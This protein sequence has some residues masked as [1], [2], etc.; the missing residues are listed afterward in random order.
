MNKTKKS[1][2][3]SKNKNKQSRIKKN[4][5][6]RFSRIKGG[7]A[8]EEAAEKRFKRIN[9]NALLS[10]AFEGVIRLLPPT[11]LSSTKALNKEFRGKVSGMVRKIEPKPKFKQQINHSNAVQLRN[12][13]ELRII[14]L[15]NTNID[16]EIL[17]AIVDSV[18]SLNAP[19]KNGGENQEVIAEIINI[20]LD[21]THVTDEGIIAMVKKF[22]KLEHITLNNIKGVTDASII[23]IAE[24]CPDL[25]KIEIEIVAVTENGLCALADSCDKLEKI[26]LWGNEGEGDIDKGII[27]IAKNCLKLREISLD[28]TGVT[29]ESIIAIAENCP[30]L[31][32]LEIENIEQEDLA[33]IAGEVGEG[34]TDKGIIAIA[35]NCPKLEHL[36]I[37][38]NTQLTDESII[39]IAE[40]CPNMWWIRVDGTGVTD[41]GIIAIAKKCPKLEQLHIGGTEVTNAAAIEIVKNC[42][43]L[44]HLWTFGSEVTDDGIRMMQELNPNVEYGRG[45]RWSFDE[46]D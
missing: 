36:D 17:K 31:E 24:N 33:T 16:D 44:S 32:R 23:A 20:F 12:Y 5:K 21:E 30:N 28:Q 8:A 15:N 4:I 1:K 19:K 29:D 18:P 27:A 11:N 37:A 9:K 35:K 26:S 46:P 22:K 45:I 7:S 10:N 2:S 39:A 40:N 34:I 14:D 25:K 41:A 42:P 6:K 13:L 3:K 38:D 43:Q